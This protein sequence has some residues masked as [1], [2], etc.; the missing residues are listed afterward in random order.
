LEIDYAKLQQEIIMQEYRLWD[1]KRNGIAQDRIQEIEA[2]IAQLK[3]QR[4]P[5]HAKAIQ[6]KSE[7]QVSVE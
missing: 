4:K 6:S 5:N 2:H 1:C 7:M 3:E